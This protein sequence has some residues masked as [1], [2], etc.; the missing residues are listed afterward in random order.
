MGT[1][2][3][4]R[5]FKSS[6]TTKLAPEQGNPEVI[7]PAIWADDLARVAALEDVSPT[8]VTHRREQ[9]EQ[10]RAAELARR[11]AEAERRKAAERRRAVLRSD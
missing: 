1:M 10:A 8:L 2:V 7:M 3:K 5:K 4:E 6:G 9:E 11:R